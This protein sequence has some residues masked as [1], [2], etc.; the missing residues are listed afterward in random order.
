MVLSPL[1]A[2]RICAFIYS[3]PPC[4][5]GRVEV[6]LDARPEARLDARGREQSAG[7][8][9]YISAVI[10][11]LDRIETEAHIT[12]LNERSRYGHRFTWR[13]RESALL[14]EPSLRTRSRGSA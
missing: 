10:R 12:I 6:F 13:P 14:L 8:R 9:F 3:A 1:Q 11:Q 2:W 7:I 5:A 4:E